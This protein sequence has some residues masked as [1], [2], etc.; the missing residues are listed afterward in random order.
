ML[1]TALRSTSNAGREGCSDGAG[2]RP[3]ALLTGSTVRIISTEVTL[4]IR[5]NFDKMGDIVPPQINEC[6]VVGCV[7]DIPG[8]CLSSILRVLQ[9]IP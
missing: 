4:L 2:V 5:T 3:L 8:E 1:A 9:Q 6:R 7:D